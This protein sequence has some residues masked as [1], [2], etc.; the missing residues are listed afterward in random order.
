MPRLRVELGERAICMLEDGMAAR[1]VA[2]RLNVHDSTI[3]NRLR[4][5]YQETNSTRDRAR[6]GR[7]RVTTQAQDKPYPVTSST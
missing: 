5:R 6:T 2:R 3:I 7:P 4:S 1:A